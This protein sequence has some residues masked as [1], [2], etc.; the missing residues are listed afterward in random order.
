MS[1]KSEKWWTTADLAQTFCI[2]QATMRRRASSG[3]W[4][5]QKIG[6]LYRFTDEDIQQIKEQLAVDTDYFYDRD[7]VARLLRKSA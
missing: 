2:S 1:A 7:R 6:K 4:P 3:Q 5:H